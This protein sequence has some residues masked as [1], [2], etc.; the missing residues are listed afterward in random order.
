M[1]FFDKDDSPAVQAFQTMLSYGVILDGGRRFP[2][3]P[4][5][6]L[7]KISVERREAL[8]DLQAQDINDIRDEDI[9]LWCYDEEKA[10]LEE[11][12]ADFRARMKRE[13]LPL[14][15]KSRSDGF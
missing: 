15:S 10:R 4:G 14:H 9:R 7:E 5:I 13:D 11:L 6:M 2:K 12:K 3:V 1:W 8:K